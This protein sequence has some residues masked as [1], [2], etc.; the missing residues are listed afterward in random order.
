[1]THPK[2]AHLFHTFQNVEES[3]SSAQVYL[4]R[5]EKENSKSRFPS[6]SEIISLL[7]LIKNIT[8]SLAKYLESLKSVFSDIEAIGA[9]ANIPIEKRE[10]GVLPIERLFYPYYVIRNH[11]NA[12]WK[13]ESATY[14]WKQTTLLY[15]LYA[16]FGNKK[17]SLLPGYMQIPLATS[18]NEGDSKIILTLRDEAIAELSMIAERA[19]FLMTATKE[20]LQ[21]DELE[22]KAKGVSFDA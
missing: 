10:L 20:Q 17:L 4:A 15:I 1:M 21:A 13:H 11:S 22:Q 3:Y 14:L 6:E 9:L 5:F 19:S 12:L 7:S 2:V 16:Y 8:A 18:G